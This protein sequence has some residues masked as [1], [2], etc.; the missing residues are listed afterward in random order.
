MDLFCYLQLFLGV[1]AETR[2]L[3]AIAESGVEML[4]S[5]LQRKPKHYNCDQ[6]GSDHIT[7]YHDYPTKD[8]LRCRHLL[9]DLIV[10][11]GGKP[12]YFLL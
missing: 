7:Y 8:E 5:R 10:S 1:K 3:L 4:F 9:T 6:Q 2:R 11:L 12:D